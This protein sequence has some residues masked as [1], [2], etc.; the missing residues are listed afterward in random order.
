VGGVT[1]STG[2]SPPYEGG[3]LCGRV[4]Y[5]ID[6]A[7]DDI[8]HCHCGMCRRASGGIVTTWA[9]VPLAAFA[10]TGDA[11]AQYASSAHARRW[12]CG[13]CGG[14]LALHT[15]RAAESIDVTVATLDRPQDHPA[16]R[17][18]WYADHLPWLE[19]DPQLPREAGETL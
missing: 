14:Q 17:H 4:R 3:C 16:T 11:P 2:S 13:G 5:R 9:T 1:A 18:I 10:W 12:F 19:I 15:T 6:A 8:A 7:L